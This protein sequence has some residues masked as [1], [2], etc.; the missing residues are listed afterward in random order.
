MAEA[1]VTG[2]FA[3]GF[4]RLLPGEFGTFEEIRQEGG[5]ELHELGGELRVHGRLLSV[6]QTVNE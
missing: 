4:G 5:E 3:E 1:L 6:G 2:F